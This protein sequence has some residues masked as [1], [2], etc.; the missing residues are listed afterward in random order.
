MSLFSGNEGMSANELLA[1]KK[2]TKAIE[3]LRR[4][5]AAR[6]DNAS[7]RLQLA[8]VLV[9]AGRTHEAAPLLA[10]LADEFVAQGF[11]AKAIAVLKK[12]QRIEPRRAGVEEKL[13]DLIRDH[14][15]RPREAIPAAWQ[16]HGRVRRALEEAERAERTP[17]GFVPAASDP[18]AA[19]ET[20]AAAPVVEQEAPA[21]SAS[22]AAADAQPPAPAARSTLPAD[23][24]TEVIEIDLGLPEQEPNLV[25]T[26]LFDGFSR[27]E[28]IEVIRGLHVV[29]YAPGDIIVSEGERGDSLYI[30]TSGTLKVFLK[31]QEGRAARTGEMGEGSFFGEISL[32]S[33]RPRTATITAA[34]ACELLELDRPTLDR[35]TKAHPTVENVLLS[36]YYQRLEQPSGGAGPVAE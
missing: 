29:S 19:A 17:A 7:T 4:E 31:D 2:F 25:T 6:P 21:Q 13:A 14:A 32:L 20:S 22:P 28:L 9:Q 5:V 33:G 34:T 16:T 36:F 18:V 8:D 24:G 26:P 23:Y 15:G 1:R 3:V 35:I 30:I 12:L 10:D 11:T 27:D